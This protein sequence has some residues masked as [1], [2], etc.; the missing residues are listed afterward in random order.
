[1]LLG[2]GEEVRYG[3]LPSGFNR[4]EFRSCWGA[5]WR[6]AVGQL[7][8][9]AAAAAA[10]GEAAANAPPPPAPAPPAP[11]PPPQSPPAEV[12]AAARMLTLQVSFLEELAG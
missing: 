6:G 8:M 5:E 10:M 3:V 11:T 9:Q 4:R 1:M 2:I 12:L 7:K